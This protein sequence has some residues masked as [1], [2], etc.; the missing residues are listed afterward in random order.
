MS[1][2]NGDPIILSKSNVK[3]H[4]YYKVF[5]WNPN[6]SVLCS[7]TAK[8]IWFNFI[9]MKKRSMAYAG[10]KPQTYDMAE[11]RSNH[12][13]TTRISIINNVNEIFNYLITIKILVFDQALQLLKN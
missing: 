12:W 6:H 3:V 7:K 4:L 2:E 5:K 10:F 1:N 9:F 13:A 11:Q 8:N